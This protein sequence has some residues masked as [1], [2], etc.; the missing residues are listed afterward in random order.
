MKK[1]III[2]FSFLLVCN[3]AWAANVTI[4]FLQW[5]ELELPAGSLRSIIDQFEDENPGIKVKLIS[6]PFSNTY[7]QIVAGA[8]T[9]TL[10][11]VVGMGGP[12]VNDLARQ[13]AIAP[14]DNFMV[15]SKLDS[16]E[17]GKI[18]KI[19]GQCFMFPVVL[20]IY[21]LY[22]NLDLFQK[23][24]IAEPPKTR[25]EFFEIAKRLTIP[26]KNQYGWVLPLSLQTP[27]GIQNEVLSWVWASGKHILKNGKP[28]LTN[29]D[30]IDAMKFVDS[31]FKAGVISPG[32]FSKTEQDKVE[33]FT[34]GRVAMMIGS[35]AHINTIRARNPSLRFT[36]SPIP[37]IDGYNGKQGILY[38]P[39]GIGISNN[40]K[41]KNEA[42]KL[43]SFLMRADINAKLASLAYAFPGNIKAKP[44]YVSSDQIY[45]KAFEI[46]QSGYLEN[47][48]IGLPVAV[49]LQRELNEEFQIMLNGKQTAE[50]A[51]AKAQ[52]RW[53]KSF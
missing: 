34:N 53:L 45:A 30:V 36:I 9:G 15:P 35:L 16:N 6:T 51:A 19:N 37:V 52:E 26:N 47:E 39:W 42:W 49:Q 31:L 7:D 27:N 23:A 46:F 3:F 44:D 1:G 11:D 33:E 40:S 17:I 21:P 38:A 24:G 29:A 50:Q 2:L 25:S 12:W 48:F 43:V 5:W 28:D 32:S 22:I 18:I 8:A 10:S 13:G 14:L 20:F 41:H 4:E